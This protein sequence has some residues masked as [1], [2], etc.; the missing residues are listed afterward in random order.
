LK[1]PKGIKKMRVSAS[2]DALSKALDLG[3]SS[4]FN[5][6]IRTTAPKGVREATVIIFIDGKSKIAVFQS[7][8]RSLYGPDALHEV[9]RIAE[10]SASTI[11]VE[12]F[13]A[14]N[15]DEVKA[16][17]KKMRKARIEVHDIERVLMGIEV[18]VEVEPKDRKAS[19]PKKKEKG[20]EP[21]KE[22]ADAVDAELEKEKKSPKAKE[23][24]KVGKVRAKTADRIAR[25][26]E[27]AT[28]GE[29]DEF[30]RMMQEAGMS[31]PTDDD[32]TMDDDDVDQY[33]AAFEDF[34][35]RSGDDD[36]PASD[37]DITAQL[38]VAVDDIID[39]M[40]VAAEDDPEMMEFIEG[41]RENILTRV[42]SGETPE[43]AKDRHERLSEQQYALEHISST[44]RD[45][46]VASETEAERR[47]K[48]LEE[49]KE[50]GESD[51]DWLKGETQEL[52]QEAE[53][54]VG[55][56]AILGKV[57]ETHRERL[58]GAEEDLLDENLE[59]EAAAKEEEVEQKEELD[60]EEAKKGFLEDMRS[61]IKSVSTEE[62]PPPTP[63]KVA[64]A[65]QD[66]SE[67]IH[68]QVEELEQEQEV[69][70]KER[71]HLE[72]QTEALQEKVDTMEVDLEV[73][74]Q[75]RLRDLE[76]RE[77]SLMDRA[78]EYED[79]EKRLEDERQK[80]EK[81]LEHARSELVK[82]EDME[83]RLKDREE[84]LDGKEME[85]EGKHKE[86]DGLKE[87]LED[88]IALRASELE[89]TE[90]S[91][92]D[93]EAELLAKEEEITSSMEALSKEREDGVEADLKRVQGMEGELRNREEEYN[94]AI[95]NNEAVIEALRE[96]LREN[97]EKVESLEGE[98]V[99]LRETEDKVRELEEK[100]ASV[101]DEAEGASDMDKEE[102]RRLLAYL[103][104]LLSRL[105]EKEIEKFSKTEYF[106]L[107]GRILDKLG[108]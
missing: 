42:V 90:Q 9:K 12:E 10:D 28:K 19:K 35:Q 13:L 40:M 24:P 108:I 95:S 96:E 93:R 3:S 16:I 6:Y 89:Q 23:P 91:L 30:L 51:A 70:T 53:R 75:G 78:K 63:G 43:T 7:P 25:S 84:L 100:L 11:R 41:Q 4:G 77:S 46:L 68:D 58:E 99:P 98:L 52:E 54:H 32:E 26:K 87:H 17:A 36:A 104:D 39:E 72:D 8:G 82:V 74:V 22:I 31:P 38:T 86:V 20:S 34:L 15:M 1:L 107:Y 2:E 61:R 85:L 69:L 101:P 94:A 5:G 103:D 76:E 83:N 71:Q 37:I 21:A 65:V 27:V 49:L 57:L 81:D 56:E 88:E 80:V 50:K 62:A 29:D 92:K 48:D 14:Q 97:I 18:E 60:L 106:E 33:I 66:V 79:L 105:P 64:E 67:E 45:V 44:F 47:R 73:E 59:A 102:L 55:L